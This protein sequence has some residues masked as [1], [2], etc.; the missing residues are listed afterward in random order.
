MLIGSQVGQR[1]TNMFGM[2][3]HDTN[4]DSCR[5]NIDNRTR[6]ECKQVLLTNPNNHIY[7]CLPKKRKRTF[8]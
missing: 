5:I 1:D 8:D 7:Q 2:F 3:F 4:D 6:Q